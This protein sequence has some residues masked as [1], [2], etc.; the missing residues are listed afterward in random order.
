MVLSKASFFHRQYLDLYTNQ[1]LPSIRNY[2][3]EN[4][5]NSYLT[6]SPVSIE[7]YLQLCY[8]AV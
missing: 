5:C 1:M 2:V 7:N 6:A 3:N 8:G 4:R